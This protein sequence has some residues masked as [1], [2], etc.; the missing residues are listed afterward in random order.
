MNDGGME[1]Q[2][3]PSN[4]MMM[5]G[6]SKLNLLLTNRLNMVQDEQTLGQIDHLRLAD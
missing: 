1:M 4:Y 6:N 2:V 3:L 5:I